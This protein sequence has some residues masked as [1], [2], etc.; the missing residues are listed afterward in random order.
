MKKPN[1]VIDVFLSYNTRDEGLAAFVRENLVA[2]GLRVKDM[3]EVTP[4]TTI[5][6]TVRE[7]LV[8][9]I[10][11]V[12]L[13]TP[14]SSRSN[15]FAF[16]AGMAMAW[17]KPIFVLFDGVDSTE[18]PAF[19]NE[20]RILPVR[21]VADVADLINASQQPLKAEH[22]ELIRRIYEET[23]IPTDQ[24]L[25]KPGVLKVMSDKLEAESGQLVSGSRIAHELVRMRKSGVLPRIKTPMP[26]S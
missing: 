23:G 20:F 17:A 11:V 5:G 21:Q 19:L 3:T 9:S 16:E 8:D 14:S 2:R 4:G 25:L 12:L 6:K 26:L 18:I 22:A 15:S 7:G 24:L 1:T 10:A 13:L